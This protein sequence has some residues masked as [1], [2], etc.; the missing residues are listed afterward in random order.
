[1]NKC[2]RCGIEI[3]SG[4]LSCGDCQSIVDL[5]AENKRLKE[6]ARKVIRAECWGYVPLDG[7]EIQELAEKS[8]L[9]QEHVATESDVDEESDFEVG[10]IIYKFTDFM[11][12]G[13]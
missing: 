12:D 13:E 10:D 3:G 4:V 5:Q 6:F 1:M 8:G 2:R 7:F 9:I 11:K